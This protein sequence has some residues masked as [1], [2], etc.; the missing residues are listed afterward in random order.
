M[1]LFQAHSAKGGCLNVPAVNTDLR[2][3][4]Y[5]HEEIECFWSSTLN[6]RSIF[7]VFTG[8]QD[9]LSSLDVPEDLFED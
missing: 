7:S 4:G 9:R 3:I 6:L 2:L 5:S 8:E 1:K